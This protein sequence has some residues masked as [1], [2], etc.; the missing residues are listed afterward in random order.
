MHVRAKVASAAIATVAIGGAV[1]MSVPSASADHNGHIKHVLLISVDGMHQ[2]DLDWYVANHPNSELA[3]LASGGA[4]FANNHTS[5]PSDSDPGGTALMTGGDPRA[6]GV[7]YD[8]EYSHGVFP[9]GT[10]NCSGPVPGG[11]AIYDSPDDKLPAV[12]DLLNN[13][14]G[15]TFPSFDEGGSIFPGGGD[16]NPGAIMNL[17]PH[18][19][20]GLDPA[21][22]PVDPTTCQPIM[23]WDY[24][25]INSIF[26]VIHNAGMRTAWS[27]KH[28]IYTSFN[29]HGSGGNSINDFFGPRD[30]LAGGR[31]ERRP[32]SDRHGLGAR[33]RRHQAVR[34]LQGPSNPE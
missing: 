1:A 2:S 34:R 6:T 12:P 24:L 20:S 19:Q 25:K 18:P 32:V 23:P 15:N 4:E 13:G 26:Q 27:D 30:R 5:D 14:S 3:K 28:A 33:R 21:T 17:S 29:G 9:P 7:Y 16:T 22:F 8:V 11:N 10:T 31:A